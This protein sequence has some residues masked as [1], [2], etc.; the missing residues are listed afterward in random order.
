MRRQLTW[1]AAVTTMLGFVASACGGG[2]DDAATEGVAATSTVAASASVAATSSVA[3]SETATAS[4]ITASDG[5]ASLLVP[6]GALPAG[7]EPGDLKVERVPN[8]SAVRSEGG[9]VL[10]TYE[11]QPD[12]LELL[13][14]VTLAVEIPVEDT[15]GYIVAIHRSGDEAEFIED[16][17]I[18]R[19]PESET[20]TASMQ[21]GHFSNVVVV[22]IASPFEAELSV[23]SD[24]ILFAETFEIQAVVRRVVQPGQVISTL[25]TPT[26][27]T[28]HWVGDGPWLL[29][30]GTMD[31]GGPA[32]P[33][34][35]SDLPPTT[36]V[37]GPTFTLPP[38]TFECTSSGTA[39]AR[40]FGGI[41]FPEE[42]EI[43]TKDGDVFTAHPT[44][45]PVFFTTSADPVT[46]VM[47]QIKAQLNAPLTTYT[48]TPELPSATIY[49]WS[50]K[51]CGVA[52][53]GSSA[54]TWV[55]DHG[56]E[57]CNSE[58]SNEGHPEATIVLLI[59][60]T[61]PISGE[62]Y[63]LKCIYPGAAFGFG[64]QCVR[65]E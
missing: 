57:D 17:T 25:T 58:H 64:P 41:T 49:S 14:P 16:L 46:C 27:T 5:N 37:S 50:G 65:E 6:S 61:L 36:S 35:V 53:P 24:E 29:R 21:I 54:G 44:M 13:E 48:V 8:D 31:V 47:P 38:T 11:L 45:H 12:G 60:G 51:S 63:Q 42:G 52:A 34:T 39:R 28:E 32:W 20:L 23:P 33:A 55:W 22:Q 3:A 59:A 2:G 10:G 15:P 4:V 19:A 43:T 18:E 7:V 62:Q 40:Y 9:E 30:E 1:I 56:T 26:L